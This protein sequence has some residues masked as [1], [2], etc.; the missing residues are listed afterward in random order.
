MRATAMTVW[1]KSLQN[2]Y[3][4]A[5]L[6]NTA[7]AGAISCS[8]VST[9][10]LTWTFRF[11]MRITLGG[12]NP[13]PRQE[14]LTF[15]SF[16]FSLRLLEPQSRAQSC[17]FS[18][19]FFFF[20]NNLLP[21]STHGLEAVD[22]PPPDRCRDRNL[23]ETCDVDATARTP[24]SSFQGGPPTCEAPWTDPEWRDT[25]GSSLLQGG[26]G[27]SPQ[28]QSCCGHTLTPH[29]CKSLSGFLLS[30]H[31]QQS[32]SRSPTQIMI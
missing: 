25:A 12:L 10:H 23:H 9:V 8:P 18:I 6:C 21:C 32:C 17:R 14:V 15:L 4:D 11:V 5:R 2:S 16:W 3:R 19:F 30:G 27:F 22:N 28:Q 7:W 1:E 24:N 29:L 26:W 31:I 20:F 13:Q